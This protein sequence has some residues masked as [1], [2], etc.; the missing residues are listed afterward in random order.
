MGLTD[1]GIGRIGSGADGAGAG[2][3]GQCRAAGCGSRIGRRW[4]PRVGEGE[5]SDNDD[6]VGS[7]ASAGAAAATGID[8]PRTLVCPVL[9][10]RAG[11][12]MAC[13]RCGMILPCPP[14]R[15]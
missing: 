9:P 10:G 11:P 15:A 13:Q 8:L 6:G 1:A 3:G 2:T 7:A 12:R 14:W 4:G 5:T